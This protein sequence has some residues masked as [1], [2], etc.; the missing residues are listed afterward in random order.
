MNNLIKLIITTGINLRKRNIEKTKKI[1]KKIRKEPTSIRIEEMKRILS[2][3]RIKYED[4]GIDNEEMEELTYKAHLFE[5]LGLIKKINERVA[6]YALMSSLHLVRPV[7]PVRKEIEEFLLK[8]FHTKEEEILAVL[9]LAEKEKT[10]A[11]AKELKRK[12]IEAA[13]IARFL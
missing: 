5:S 12:T 8:K 6:P 3:F 2:E 7:T 13:E 4:I 9:S 11:R 10:V 1:L